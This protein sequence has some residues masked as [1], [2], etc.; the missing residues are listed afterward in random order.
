VSDNRKRLIERAGIG[1]LVIGVLL[2]VV[3]VVF[4][5]LIA[6]G[7]G[8]ESAD[9]GQTVPAGEP[10][11]ST[12]RALA[13]PR[14]LLVG[15]AVLDEPLLKGQGYPTTLARVQR[16]DTREC[17]E[18]G[19]D[20]SRAESLRL[21][22]GR[23]DRALARATTWRCADTPWSGTRQV[24]SWVTDRSWTRPELEQVLHDH[25]RRAVGHYRGKIS[26]W[27]VVN[28]AVD[29]EGKLRDSVLDAGHR[30]EYIDLAFTW[31]HEADPDAKALLQRLTTSSSRRQSGRERPRARAQSAPR[32]D[33][34]CRDPGARADG[35]P[36]RP[37]TELQSALQVYAGLGLDVG[38][39]ELDAA[40]Y[41]P[42]SAQKL[43]EQ[44]AV[45][46]DVLDACL[47]VSR[48]RT[49]V[50]WGFTDKYS[51]IPGELPGFGDAL[52]FDASY[53]PKPAFT[54][55]RRGLARGH[56]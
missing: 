47:A 30:T 17:D 44:A 11:G 24:P 46:S 7:V 16:G 6:I 36:A 37:K 34:R 26:Q 52:P 43:D 32:A 38:I 2:V 8:D 15:A 9:P 54:A 31:A 41:L 19:R 48:C 3:A 14:Q 4:G 21:R 56:R 55:I 13:G 25:I 10:G 22:A 33:R 1:L 35:A 50:T 23:L 20:P 29:S 28:E 12:L 18:M 5:V 51:W 27:D 45:Y 53:A 42:T 39:T 40:I 49:F